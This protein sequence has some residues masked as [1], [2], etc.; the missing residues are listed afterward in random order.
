MFVIRNVCIGTV[1]LFGKFNY[2]FLAFFEEFRLEDLL[3]IFA[4]R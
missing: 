4:I 3:D 2:F 1:N